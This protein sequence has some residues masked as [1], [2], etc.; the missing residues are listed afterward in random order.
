MRKADGFTREADTAARL[1]DIKVISLSTVSIYIDTSDDARIKPRIS[2]SRVRGVAVGL[3]ERNS[4]AKLEE[5][6]TLAY[7]S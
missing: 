4:I 2:I 3:W 5:N 1:I 7:V 6:R